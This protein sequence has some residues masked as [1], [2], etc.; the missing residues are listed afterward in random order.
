MNTRTWMYQNV[1]L[2]T[3]SITGEVNE[4]GLAELYCEEHNISLEDDGSAPD[5]IYFIADEIARR[6][7]IKT[8]AREPRIRADIGEFF[9]HVDSCFQLPKMRKE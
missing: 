1:E 7:E 9:N 5:N 6:H 4:S 2:F 3:D 8:G